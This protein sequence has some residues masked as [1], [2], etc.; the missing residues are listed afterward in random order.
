MTGRAIPATRAWAGIVFFGGRRLWYT[1]VMHQSARPASFWV[2]E[3]SWLSYVLVYLLAFT[4][5]LVFQASP[6][7]A[8]PDS[9]YH[10]KMALLIRDQGVIRHFPWLDLTVLGRQYTDQH[11]LYH[12]ALIPFVTWFPP[13]IGLKLATVVFGA[14]L[15]TVF[16]WAGRRL[17][18]RWPFLFVLILL[19]VRP[20]TFR[21]SLAKAPSTSL[22]FL[23]VGLVWMFEYK[24]K[25]LFVLA[26]AYVWYY[27]GFPLLGLSA[28]AVSGT[29]WLHNKLVTRHD[30]HRFVDKVMSLVGRASRHPRRRWPNLALML[31][32]ISGLAAGVVFN[33][34]FP[35]NFFFY[36]HQLIN[37]GVINFQKVIGVGNEWYPYRVG[38]LLANGAL[39]SLL[40]LIAIV[41]IILR[42]RAQSK[43]SWALA[44]LTL[45]AFVLTLKSR[46]YVEYYIPLAVLFAAVSITD[47]L[48][49]LSW[50][51]IVGQ[52]RDWFFRRRAGRVTGVLVAVYLALGIGYV[53]GRDFRNELGDLHQGFRADKFQPVSAWLATNTPVGSRIVHSDWDEFPV[54]FYY[55]THNTYIV[56]LDPTFLY[57]ANPNTYWTWA[58]ITLG[59]FQGDLV[60]AVRDT[61]KSQYV[62][63]AAGHDVM[64]RQFRNNPSFR[65]VYQDDEATVYQLINRMALR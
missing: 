22:I 30:S 28:A 8:D 40:I 11:L 43:R 41:G 45:F 38:D 64:D 52:F 27:G 58:N 26:G 17:G 35:G 55:N 4:L 5:L 2:R 10:A 12:V 54:L 57:K 59:K 50:P 7:F 53:A 9:F 23:I 34:Y 24:L 31:T 6:Y 32:V 16:Y 33:P 46:R 47:T 63:V 42:G 48:R 19:A 39:A 25:R 56:G 36:W 37:I 18:V 60:T 3:W 49:G 21:M 44:V 20:L 61:L 29:S 51:R 65:R 13:L 15:A 14:A 62:F 1:V